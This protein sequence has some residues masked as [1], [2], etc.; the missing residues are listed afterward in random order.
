MQAK[1]EETNE[2]PPF[3]VPSPPT[4]RGVPAGAEGLRGV[5]LGRREYYRRFVPLIFSDA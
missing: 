3:A 2:V 1:V 4:L 5:L